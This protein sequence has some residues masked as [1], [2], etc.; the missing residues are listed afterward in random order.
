MKRK[1]RSMLS[2][3][4]IIYLIIGSLITIIV[5]VGLLT[6]MS[7]TRSYPLN[8]KLEYIGQRDYGCYISFII[9]DSNPGV[10]LSYATNMN[11]E[12]L[13]A[14]FTNASLDP[15]FQINEWQNKGA[16]FAMHFTSIKSKDLFTVHYHRDVQKRINDFDLKETNKTFVI[17]ID[18]KYYEA[19]KSSL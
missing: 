5:A 2:K 18:K 17:D 14:H 6:Y 19:I 13:A 10:T 15:S 4:K 3:S 9:C 7:S 1:T 8:N 12:Q 11:P 16:S